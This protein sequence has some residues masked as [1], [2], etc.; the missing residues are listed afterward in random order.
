M[1]A[2]GGV[3]ALL[4]VLSGCA[5]APSNGA[6]RTT[7]EVE[8]RGTDGP[9]AL[10]DGLKRAVE[11]ALG[12][13][14]AATT[15]VEAAIAVRRRIWTDS[16]GAVEKWTVLGERTEDGLTVVRV[17]A[18]VRR[19][20]DGEAVPPPDGTTV[21]IEASGAAAA[22][23][24]RGFGARGFT[25]VEKGEQFVVRARGGSTLLRD[26]RTAPFVSA[27]GKVTVSVI[28]AASGGVV[29][30]QTREAGGLES[31]SLA[32][33]ALAV[34]NAGELGGRDAADGLAGVLWNR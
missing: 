31:D 21:R 18:V 12:V 20:A 27:R 30:E 19:L 7:V 11:K 10:A 24:R 5:T 23:V 4:L 28:D 29:W 15:K 32:A 33:A 13:K 26:A 34:E 17:R 3:L 25:V 8:G 2:N 16:R 9:Q 1:N 14:L 6:G 22:G